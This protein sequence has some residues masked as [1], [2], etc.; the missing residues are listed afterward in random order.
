MKALLDAPT[1][2][3]RILTHLPPIG[4]TACPLAHAAGR[5]L[6]EPV[7]AD[8]PFPPFDRAM[9][10]GFALR[11]AETNAGEC[12]TITAQALAGT[13]QTTIGEIP[14]ACAEI[15]TGAVLPS[16]A[17][18]V[19]PYEETERLDATHIRLLSPGRYHAG[20]AVHACGSDHESGALLLEPGRLLGSR[21]IAV[22]ATCGYDRLQVSELPTIAIASTGDELVAV[23]A[24]P[25]P[26][27]IR[28]SNDLAIHAALARAQLAVRERIHLPDHAETCLA[29]LRAL[30]ARNRFVIISGGI[31]MGQKDLIPAAL[32]A[33][34]L[35]CHFH[36]VAQK[37]G[38]P[39]GFWSQ[40]GCAVFALPGNPL[41]TLSCLHHY[42]IPAIHSAQQAVPRPNLRIIR[43]CKS[44]RVPETLAVFMPVK[45][46]EANLA[47][48][49]PP[50]N[51]GDL[52]SILQSDGYIQIPAGT[53]E[54]DCNTDYP[55]QP[56]W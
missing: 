18:C 23:D 47:T 12:F 41:S 9:M 11:A 51:S 28:R 46:E 22:A 55:F 2:L 31:S 34:G 25:E 3:A 38:K 44:V 35:V 26:H 33:L 15:M 8:R 56:W 53:A 13:P 32:N 4:I 1:A 43:L 10:D 52:V 48:P 19:V 45:L 39:M 30:T 5:I 50:Q 36:G 27:Q 17:D 7:H 14:G 29:Q 54:A 37:P 21:E 24:R 16:D 49:I 6:R 42:G 20:E 40:A